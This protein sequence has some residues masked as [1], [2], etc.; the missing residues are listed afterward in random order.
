M[1]RRRSRQMAF[2]GTTRNNDDDEDED[3]NDTAHN[4]D[5][6]GLIGYGNFSR[7]QIA[8]IMKKKKKIQ[9]HTY[10]HSP[11]HQ[12]YPPDRS[13]KITGI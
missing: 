12:S 13:T 1:I 7:E 9:A 4:D 3:D 11:L 2:I 5:Y 6:D 8:E 10:N